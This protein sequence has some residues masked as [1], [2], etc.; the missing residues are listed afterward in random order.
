MITLLRVVLGTAVYLLIVVLA[1]PFPAAAG[2]MLTFPTLN[3]LAFVFAE[4][5]RIGGMA[6]SMLWMPV[7]N[8]ALCAAYLLLWL[9]LAGVVPATALAWLLLALVLVLWSVI[10]FRTSLKEGI[11]PERRVAYTVMATLAGAVLT[12]CAFLLLEKSSV[13]A[14]SDWSGMFSWSFVRHALAQN[15]V[16]I[17][18]FVLCLSAFLIAVQSFRLS[19][20]VQGILAGLPF[21]PFA[22]LVSV[23]GDNA[24]DPDARREILERMAVSVWFGPAIAM[25]F[26]YGFSR[27]LTLRQSRDGCAPGGV[28]TLPALALGWL[29]CGLA[30]AAI[31]S[32]LA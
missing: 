21:V 20:G 30:I 27:Y 5:G 13:A 17:V 12:G 18:L 24:L 8:G 16:K 3:G 22:G 9:L 26:I 29:L 6:G 7:L 4:R 10:A 11:A 2:L 19:D 1:T 23:A 28:R 32:L 15:W 31:T 14:V 25:W